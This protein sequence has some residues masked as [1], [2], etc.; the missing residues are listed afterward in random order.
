MSAT[1][2]S[3]I[4]QRKRAAVACFLFYYC[5]FFPAA[6]AAAKN[7]TLCAPTLFHDAPLLFRP[8]KIITTTKNV[9]GF[10]K[11]KS[12]KFAKAAAAATAMTTIKE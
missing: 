1:E 6:T 7:N 2:M 12:E 10:E 4:A 3:P 9:D 5:P 8:T 11:S